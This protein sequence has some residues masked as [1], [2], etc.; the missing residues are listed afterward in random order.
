MDNYFE[1]KKAFLL[2]NPPSGGVDPDPAVAAPK[3]PE[4]PAGPDYEKLGASISRGLAAELKPILESRAEAPAA[5]PSRVAESPVPS[6]DDIDA[7][8]AAGKPVG[9]MIA[10]REAAMAAR[11]QQQMDNISAQGGSVLGEL[12]MSEIKGLPNYKRCEAGIK[13]RMEQF[14][15]ANPGAMITPGHWKTA[16]DLE[17]GARYDELRAADKE[18]DIRATREAAEAAAAA[19][20]GSRAAPLPEE[21][22]TTLL[23][24]FG[25]RASGWA[26]R[27]GEKSRLVGGRTEDGEID[28]FDRAYRAK[29]PS[30]GFD[31][32]GQPIKPPRRSGVKAFITERRELA[33]IQEED[34]SFGLGS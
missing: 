24:E 15:K 4:A 30:E 14:K 17:V 5:A 8:I 1:R 22:P 10:R 21:E 13:S 2:A 26:A 27:F 25:G 28:L 9:G 6:P 33:K 34:P 3:A 7:A 31:E 23:E 29:T 18:A 32:K 19:P 16:Y 12:S 20:A 11:M